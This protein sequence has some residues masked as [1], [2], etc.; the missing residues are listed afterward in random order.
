[1]D[2]KNLLEKWTTLKKKITTKK[3]RLNWKSLILWYV[4]IFVSFIPVFIEA[5]VYLASHDDLDW[6]F[7]IQLS[8]CGDLLWVLA[9]IMAISVID[10]IGETKTNFT[11]IKKVCVVVAV[12]LWGCTCGVWVIF[13]YI[14]P[15]EF[16]NTTPVIITA[17][18]SAITVLVCSPLHVE[19]VGER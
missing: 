16:A 2:G 13:K 14:Y 17:I 4:G 1:M 8:L 18:F 3:K 10:Y 11:V 5:I 9:T 19:E 12:I 15:S 6:N 7:W